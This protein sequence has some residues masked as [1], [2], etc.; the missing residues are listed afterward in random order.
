[1]SATIQR[2]PMKRVLTE[3]TN[4][5]GNILASPRSAKKLKLDGAFNKNFGTP[6]KDA[7]GSVNSSQPKS[8]FEEEVLEKLTQYIHDFDETK[9]S[10]CFQQIEAEEGALHGGKTTIKLFGVTEVRH[11]IVKANHGANY[12]LY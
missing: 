3:A 2:T 8:Q 4:A 1:M 12:L 11:S 6:R 10:L 7:R 9:D 5:R